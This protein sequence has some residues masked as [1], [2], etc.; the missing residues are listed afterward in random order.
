MSPELSMGIKSFYFAMNSLAFLFGKLCSGL[1]E[2][3]NRHGVDIWIDEEDHVSRTQGYRMLHIYGCEPNVEACANQIRNKLLNR[4]E[5]LQAVAV[6]QSPDILRPPIMKIEL[7]E[8][9][10]MPAFVSNIEDNGVIFLQLPS[11]PSFPKL[12]RM[13]EHLSQCC[14]NPNTPFIDHRNG[15]LQIECLVA[16]PI[17]LNDKNDGWVRARVISQPDD[18]GNMQLRSLD[19]GW[20]FFSSVTSLKALAPEFCTL[21]MQ[22]IEARVLLKRY[23]HGRPLDQQ[24]NRALDKSIVKAWVKIR[25]MTKEHN[26]WPVV[27]IWLPDTLVNPVLQVPF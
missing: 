3:H 7:A 15:V 22:A 4:G 27:E 9:I 10:I 24:I 11:I 25:A 17:Q 12:A 20:T 8:T 23:D 5:A 1:Q 19:H 2:Y 18:E 16:A 13:E 21:P 14:A 6:I 26:L